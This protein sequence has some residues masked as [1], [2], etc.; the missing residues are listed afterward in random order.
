MERGD[1]KRRY[2]EKK[3]RYKIYKEGVNMERRQPQTGD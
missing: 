2:K 3:E 1:T